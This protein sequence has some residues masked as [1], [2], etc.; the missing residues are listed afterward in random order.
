MFCHGH[1]LPEHPRVHVEAWWPRWLDY[2][3]A[4]KTQK[5]VV[6]KMIRGSV[7]KGWGSWKRD[8]C[9]GTLQQPAAICKEATKKIPGSLLFAVVHGRTMGDNWPKLKCKRFRLD[10]SKTFFPMGWVKQ[11]IRRYREVVWSLSFEVFR[12]QQGK[13]LNKLVWWP[14]FEQVIRLQ[15]SFPAWFKLE[16]WGSEFSCAGK[17]LFLA[18]R[19]HQQRTLSSPS[20]K[21]PNFSVS[22]MDC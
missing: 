13:A 8:R 6:T 7:R 2:L 11:W 18:Y 14:C 21:S 19:F 1:H 22:I 9:R 10:I 5:A 15:T 12:T 3:M 4:G 17:G 20:Y 16:I